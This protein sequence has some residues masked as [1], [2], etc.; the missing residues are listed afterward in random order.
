MKSINQ[1]RTH[2]STSTQLINFSINFQLYQKEFIG[3]GV[4]IYNLMDD[5]QEYIRGLFVIM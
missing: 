3:V 5:M 1:T 4:C 2:F